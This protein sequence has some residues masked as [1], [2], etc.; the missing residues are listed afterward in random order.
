MSSTFTITRDQVIQLALRK[1]G[2]LELGETPDTVTVTNASFALNLLIKQ[3]ATQG[4]K[5]WKI[6]NVVVPLTANQT[7]YTIGPTI[8]GPVDV[9]TEKPLK[10]LQGWLRNTSVNP[11]IDIPLNPLSQQEYNTLGSKF[12]TG[13][14][15]SYYYQVRNKTGNLYVFLTPDANTASMY[16]LYLTVQQPMNDLSKAADIPDFPNEWMNA[17]VWNL[18]DQLAI[19]YSVPA[20][21]RQEITARATAYRE[22]LTDWDVEVT[23][24]FFQPNMRMANMV[25]GNKA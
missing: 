6:T 18:A 1:L 2:V 15:N 19:E 21:H 23:S 17:L 22:E 9:E 13:V 24:T 10:V 7:M 20:N 3:M 4:L 14:I 8:D 5:I 16:D 11:D 25:T 12:S